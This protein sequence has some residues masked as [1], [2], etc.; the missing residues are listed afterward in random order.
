MRECCDIPVGKQKS[1]LMGDDFYVYPTGVG[2]RP[3]WSQ[4]KIN[5]TKPNVL[6]CAKEFKQGIIVVTMKVTKKIERGGELLA[7]IRT[8]S[9]KIRK[10]KA[11]ANV[12]RGPRGR[13][14][15]F[16]SIRQELS[17]TWD[18]GKTYDAFVS[19]YHGDKIVIKFPGFQKD[20]WLC[21]L[22]DYA[23]RV[24]FRAPAISKSKGMYLP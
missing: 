24:R 2:K 23:Q 3:L 14:S 22:K 13:P 17:V 4:M 7:F 21:N 10:T 15:W 20:T 9:R 6:L 5:T 16:P 18:D 1:V 12:M 8:R 19:D 11:S